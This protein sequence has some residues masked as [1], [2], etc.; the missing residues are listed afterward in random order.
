MYKI[1]YINSESKIKTRDIP[2]I[3]TG[4][5]LKY[6]DFVVHQVTDNNIVRV[7]Q[8]LMDNTYRNALVYVVKI[9]DDNVK[10][11]YQAHNDFKLAFNYKALNGN[12]A[13]VELPGGAYVEGQYL[14]KDNA[15]ETAHALADRWG[16]G[17]LN[18]KIQKIGGDVNLYDYR[19]KQ[20]PLQKYPNQV[21]SVELVEALYE[22]HHLQ[23]DNQYIRNM[24]G[25]EEHQLVV[26]IAEKNILPNE[27]F[28]KFK[29]RVEHFYK[30][31]RNAVEFKT[32]QH[33]ETGQTVE[34]P[35]L[36]VGKRNNFFLYTLYEKEF[37]LCN[38]FDDVNY[39]NLTVEGMDIRL[40]NGGIIYADNKYTLKD[41]NYEDVAKHAGSIVVD[42][43]DLKNKMF[44]GIRNVF[45]DKDKD[46]H[47]HSFS[48]EN[49]KKIHISWYK[50][51]SKTNG[52]DED[53]VV[54][55]VSTKSHYHRYA[56]SKD[57]EG[58][59][60]ANLDWYSD[61]L[62]LPSVR[63]V[64]NTIVVT[65]KQQLLPQI[66]NKP[67]I[68]APKV[69]QLDA[70]VVNVTL[71]ESLTRRINEI[72]LLS[73]TISNKIGENIIEK[74]LL[75][76]KNSRVETAVNQFNELYKLNPDKATDYVLRFEGALDNMKTEMENKIE[77]L[78]EQD[79]NDFEI[80]LRMLENKD[81]TL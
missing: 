11:I 69:E 25:K 46:E 77:Q 59:T 26:K 79:S 12:I 57:F 53:C 67:L 5:D 62:D 31:Y 40:G 64:L 61:S 17:L 8:N 63:K 66:D 48:L 20:I 33:I 18:A 49:D 1:G 6:G 44:D 21:F 28:E 32:L 80:A 76:A 39:K 74:E 24:V 38:G 51:A 9:E 16:N 65:N 42:N 50:D 54:V 4:G 10:N 7:A 23:R 73:D 30:T 29:N 45:G 27:S 52:V 55:R 71:P 34:V 78:S 43:K 3:Y 13:T 19:D 22:K 35:I 75:N 70:P 58:N 56:I 15:L 60:A 14:L 2:E 81:V 37:L 72:K 36:D 41:I 47:S 68:E